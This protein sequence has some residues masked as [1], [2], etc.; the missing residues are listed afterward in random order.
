MDR[1]EPSSGLV[2]S[3]A[4]WLAPPPGLSV[5]TGL[6]QGQGGAPAYPWDTSIVTAGPKLWLRGD[7]VTLNSGNVSVWPDQS[8][9]ANHVVQ[10]VGANQPAW[11]ANDATYN[12]KPT[13]N[14]VGSKWM[15]SAAFAAAIAQPC[16]WYVVG[17]SSS[18]TA[19]YRVFV[20]GID[21]N[22][23]I[24]TTNVTTGLLYAYAGSSANTDVPGSSP[25]IHAVVVNGVASEYHLNSYGTSNVSATMGTNTLAGVT[26]GAIQGGAASFLNGTIAEVILFPGAHNAAQRKAVMSYLATRYARPIAYTTNGLRVW[27]RADLGMTL[28]GVDR[29]RVGGSKRFRQSSHAGDCRRAT[30]AGSEW[31]KRSAV[32]STRWRQR[33][34]DLSDQY[35][36]GSFDDVACCR[37]RVWRARGRSGAVCYA[38]E[39]CLRAHLGSR[40]WADYVAPGLQLSGHQLGAAPRVMVQVVRAAAD[41]DLVD[42]GSLVNFTTGTGFPARTGSALFADPS[43]LQFTDTELYELRHYNRALTN[44]ERAGIVADAGAFHSVAVV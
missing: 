43:G 11:V 13:L 3:G 15:A 1:R 38:E 42:N 36:D 16:T 44:A 8:G 25:H 24:I 37:A 31:R 5:A 22:R 18:S 2:V 32:R 40:P 26:L 21:A 27:L 20:D 30:F 6:E 14:F 28:N 9:N 17:H 7:V 35:Y 33:Y 34:P 10:A 12:G 19:D 29:G 39:R 4:P 41:I 23:H